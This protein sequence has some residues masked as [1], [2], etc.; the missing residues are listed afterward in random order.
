M[1]RTSRGR[2]ADEKDAQACRTSAP[3]L[4]T[5]EGIAAHPLSL[6]RYSTLDKT[7]C[8]KKERKNPT[9]REKIREQEPDVRERSDEWAMPELPATIT[10]ANDRAGQLCMRITA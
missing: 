7:A 6:V 4:R 10:S 9:R 2:N 5:R 3:G 1:L 8:V